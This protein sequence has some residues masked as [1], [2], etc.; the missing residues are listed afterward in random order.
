MSLDIQTLLLLGSFIG[1]AP[2]LLMPL[3]WRQ[4]RSATCLLTWGGGHLI[5]AIGLLTALFRGQVP[6]GIPIQLG[7]ALLLLYYAALWGAVRQFDGR[8]LLTVGMVAGPA[9]WLIACQIPAFYT[10]PADRTMLASAIAGAYSLAA[11]VE[12]WRGRRERL[13]SRWFLIGLFLLIALHHAGQLLFGRAWPI[14]DMTGP[15]PMLTV[16]SSFLLLNLVKERSSFRYQKEAWLDPLTGVF[17]RRGFLEAAARR[18]APRRRDRAPTAAALLLMD[19]DRFKQINDRFG[20]TVG[21]RVLRLFVAVARA[22]LAPGDVLGRLGGEEFAALLPG[23]DAPEAM[24]VADRIRRAF[25]RAAAMVDGCE[26]DARVSIG[27]AAH[28]HDAGG[29]LENLLREADAALYRAKANGRD[30][31]EMPAAEL[32]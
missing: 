5:G 32:A 3:V 31:V 27:V 13:P 26:V 20:H 21:D 14:P 30:R 28:R 10:L 9:L 12:L 25:A 6:V 7:N 24:A 18:T 17:N 2:G 15:P 1:V 29:G 22:E 4:E 16:V 8:R 11:A 19:L 23:G